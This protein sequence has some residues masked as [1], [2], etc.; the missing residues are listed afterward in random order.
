[1]K[2]DADAGEHEIEREIAAAKLRVGVV[3]LLVA[4]KKERNW[5][6]D[7]RGSYAYAVES[8]LPSRELA[9]VMDATNLP[10]GVRWFEVAGQR[11]FPIYGPSGGAVSSSI[12]YLLA[13]RNPEGGTDMGRE[14]DQPFRR[15]R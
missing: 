7:S 10:V 9:S 13:G 15:Y 6:A 11:I 8:D 14:G 5:S 1:M 2:L 3:A 4:L 12:I